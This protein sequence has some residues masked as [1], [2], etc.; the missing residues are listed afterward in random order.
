MIRTAIYNRYSTDL[1]N[2][3]S[4][5]DQERE[6]RKLAGALGLDVVCVYSDDALSGSSLKRPGMQRLIADVRA[7]RIDMV[8]AEGLHRISR[9]LADTAHFCK[10]ARF[11][12]VRIWTRL[13][14]EIGDIHVAIKGTMN[15]LYL[16]E[17]AEMTRRGQ[18]GRILQGRSAGGISYGYRKRAGFHADGTPI[19]GER[20]VDLGEAEVVLRIFK[21]YANGLSPKQIA[22]ALNREGVVGPRGGAWGASTI[23]G[24]KTRGTGILN[25]ELYVGRLVW[26]R[27]RFVKD[28]DTDKRQARPNAP[29]ECIVEPVPDL[30]IVDDALWASVKDRQK[31]TAV[32]GE[33]GGMW[34]H[35]RPR[36]LFSGMMTC[37]ACGGGFSKISRDRFGC[38]TARNKGDSVCA[39]RRTIKCET[40]EAAV[41]HGLAEH[42]MDPELVTLFCE[43]YTREANRLRDEAASGLDEVTRKLA[44]TRREQERLVKALREGVPADVVK[45]EMWKLDAQAKAL[46]A[47]IGA[48]KDPDPV[49]LHPSMADVYRSEVRALVSKLSDPAAAVEAAEAV[50]R[51]VD[52]IVLRP[53]PEAQGGLAIDL[54]GA[55]AGILALAAGGK[56]PPERQV[57]LVAGAGFEPATFRL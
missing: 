42:L 15:A 35:R 44:A 19:T 48:T 14:N 7:R 57:K 38:S 39:N 18:K 23:N 10:L 52:R 6:N 12:G 41:L 22:S 20:N 13:E 17:L 2:D 56:P 37:G 5:E 30:R 34:S 46:E 4:N 51:L 47:E 53:D 16:T 45:A 9:D 50:R 36:H 43:E 28:P 25:N 32:E 29:D 21:D 24:N 49:R 33:G 31:A 26:N 8:I 11:S 3:A 27:Q 55:L 54:E 1:Q 40:V